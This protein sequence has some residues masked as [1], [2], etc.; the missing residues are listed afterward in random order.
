MTLEHV[1]K[2]EFKNVSCSSKLLAKVID[3]IR[4]R[5]DTLLI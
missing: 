1:K 3:A 5:S 4:T 2:R